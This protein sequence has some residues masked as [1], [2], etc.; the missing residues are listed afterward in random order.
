MP[1]ERP[2]FIHKQPSQPEQTQPLQGRAEGK[3]S[4]QGPTTVDDSGQPQQPSPEAGHG[5]NDLQI[6]PQEQPP[7]Q[8]ESLE[9]NPSASP[10]DQI[11]N[12]SQLPQTE[13]KRRKPHSPET[14]QKISESQ[15]KRPRK[16]HSPE[17]RAKIGVAHKGKTISPET[18]AKMAAT[19]KGKTISPETRQKMSEGIRKSW[20]EP[21]KKQKMSRAIS[22]GWYKRSTQQYAEREMK[23]RER[24]KAEAE[25]T[26]RLIFSIGK[27]PINH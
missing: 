15:K 13:R 18:R 19:H 4:F 14:R 24:Q 6:K 16:P 23:E 20:C 2:D 7:F 27:T 22:K 8:P 26:A 17:T 11:Q 25:E 3:Q 9:G 1:G 21:G 10:V 12:D 5:S